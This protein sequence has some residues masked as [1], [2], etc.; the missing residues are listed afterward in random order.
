MQWVGIESHCA[1][2]RWMVASHEI[3]RT[4]TYFDSTFIA[5]QVV[6]VRRDITNRF[7]QY[8][9]LIEQIK[10]PMTSLEDMRNPLLDENTDLHAL[11]S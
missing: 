3:S 5:K 4:L 10:A 8:S 7:L 9:Q 2:T 6:K 1:F 11:Y